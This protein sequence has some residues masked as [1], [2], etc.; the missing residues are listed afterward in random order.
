MPM[1]SFADAGT[2]SD[3]SRPMTS[4]ISARTPGTSALGRSTLLMTGMISRSWSSAWYTFAS[5]CAS[6]PWVASTTRIA[7]SHAAS[8]RDTSYAKSTCPGVSMRF[9]S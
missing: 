1:P 7:P 3:A 9:S 4:S 8:E 6:T 5:V 2:A